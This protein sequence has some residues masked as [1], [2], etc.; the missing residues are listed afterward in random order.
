MHVSNQ[1]NSISQTIFETNKTT[2]KLSG[3][4]T[5]A[6]YM[7]AAQSTLVTEGS[8]VDKGTNELALPMDTNKGKVEI[9]LDGYYTSDSLRQVDFQFVI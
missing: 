8:S 4:S 5:F 9:N 7:K 3:S 2:A 6:D 1:S